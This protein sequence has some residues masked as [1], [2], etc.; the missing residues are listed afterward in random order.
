M[1]SQVGNSSTPSGTSWFEEGVNTGDQVATAFT[2][3]SP[4]GFLTTLHAYAATFT[5]TAT[6]E[7]CVWDNSGSLLASVAA[8]S[9]V[10]AGAP[11]W[12]SGTLLGNGQFIA[13]GVTIYLGWTCPAANGFYAAYNSGGSGR[14]NE[15]SSPPGG[16]T[17]GSNVNTWTGTLGTYADYT[18]AGIYVNTGTP[19]SPVWT[20]APVFINTGTPASPVWTAAPMY[21]QTGTPASPVWTPTS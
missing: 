6:P 3:P 18:P 17:G 10:S 8:S 11:A 14:W 7:L 19:A 21:V 5:G 4:G 15:Q 16:L 12:V 9:S 20:P 1:S 2:M 13:G